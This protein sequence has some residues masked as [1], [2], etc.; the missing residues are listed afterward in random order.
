MDELGIYFACMS[1]AVQDEDEIDI[2]DT[3]A[4]QWREAVRFSFSLSFTHLNYA[5]LP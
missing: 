3:E 1:C 2:Y 4:F 5:I